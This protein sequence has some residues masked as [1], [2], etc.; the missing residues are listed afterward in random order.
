LLMHMGD[1]K[2]I[3]LRQWF[4]SLASV[5]RCSL[6]RCFM[7]RRGRSRD[8]DFPSSHCAKRS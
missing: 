8:E 7:D 5:D 4:L 1:L 6:C 2:P 3:C